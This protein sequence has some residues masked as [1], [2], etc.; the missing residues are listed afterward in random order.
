MKQS[1]LGR[2]HSANLDG[3][4]EKVSSGHLVNYFVC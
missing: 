1:E 2:R 3:P 4:S